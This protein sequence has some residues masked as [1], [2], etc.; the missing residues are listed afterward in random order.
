MAP[1]PWVSGTVF[2]RAKARLG[3][4]VW[5]T[6]HGSSWLV[7]QPKDNGGEFALLLEAQI[8]LLDFWVDE[9]L[10]ILHEENFALFHEIGYG[11]RSGNTH[12]DFTVNA[13]GKTEVYYIKL[14]FSDSIVERMYPITYDP[15]YEGVVIL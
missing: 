13:K 2:K 14:L 10:F 6:H 3:K 4:P 1:L 11:S 8:R 12:S 7:R 15:F 5:W 9:T